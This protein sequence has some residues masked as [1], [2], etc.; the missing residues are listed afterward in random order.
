MSRNAC[1]ALP[2]PF[3]ARPDL[4]DPSGEVA[5]WFTAPPGI[6]FQFVRPTHGR[7]D[8]A[9]WVTG[10]AHRALRA[11][12]PEA[13]EFLCVFDLRLMTSRDQAGRALLLRRSLACK[14][15]FV[16]SFVL[17]P[18]HAGPIYVMSVQAAVT[19]LRVMGIPVEVNQSLEEVI[20]SAPLRPAG[21]HVEFKSS[22]RLRP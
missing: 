18:E 7:L 9:T 17:L 14:G 8:H 5:A 4:R 3:S 1:H 20:D 15:L 10:A 13:T 22:L 16:R 19:L 11:R 6:V 21:P 12:F 2:A